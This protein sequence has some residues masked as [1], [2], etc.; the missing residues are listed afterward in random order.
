MPL[1][2]FSLCL[3]QFFPP[4]FF[5]PVLLCAYPF[6]SLY[7]IIYLFLYLSLLSFLP[8]LSLSL[9]GFMSFIHPPFPY[10]SLCF[11]LSDPKLYSTPFINAEIVQKYSPLMAVIVEKIC[12]DK[13]HFCCL[14]F[15]KCIS[16]PH[17]CPK[18]H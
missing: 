5:V 8:F 14:V 4:P 16:K 1:Q 12:N 13:L 17:H 11:C 15:G 6:S 7:C 10:L 9:S 18:L 2:S 3:F